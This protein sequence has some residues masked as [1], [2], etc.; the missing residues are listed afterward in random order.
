MGN[1]LVKSSRDTAANRCKIEAALELV[2][3]TLPPLPAPADS[4]ELSC[5]CAV[6][7]K[8]YALRFVRQ[9]SGLFRLVES[10]K[11]QPV[12][13]VMA[14]G[15][16]TGRRSGIEYLRL[17]EFERG[18]T[19]CAWC[20]DRSYH[21]CR[22]NCGALVCGGRMRGRTFRCRASCGAE[23]VGEP[24]REVEAVTGPREPE[25]FQAPAPPSRPAPAGGGKTP[26]LLA[27]T[28]QPAGR[29]DLLRRDVK[30]G[31]R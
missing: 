19:R 23:W 6:H 4:C 5:V 31:K 11:V 21:Y 27:G 1:E 20:G 25:R 22:N 30:G 10:V 8:P 28:V 17:D 7:D 26:L 15:G 14:E 9:A 24:L 2:G 3:Q 12:E 16:E 13:L 29:Y 18:S